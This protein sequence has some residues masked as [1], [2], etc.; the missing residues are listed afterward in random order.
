MYVLHLVVVQ[1]IWG[2]GGIA[3]YVSL[4]PNSNQ[5]LQENNLSINLDATR[6]FLLRLFTRILM[7]ILHWN[8]H[9]NYM[10]SVSWFFFNGNQH[11]NL[12][13]ADF[14]HSTMWTETK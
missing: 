8:L 5:S 1:L 6:N 4:H 3:D 13:R 14:E 12:H 7:Q 2:G 11:N 10:E 9:E